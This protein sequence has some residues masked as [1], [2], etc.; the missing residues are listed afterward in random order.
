M[1]DQRAAGPQVRSGGKAMSDSGGAGM[2]RESSE[3]EQPMVHAEV[4]GRRSSGA[5][6][7]V[8]DRGRSKH[9][10]PRA[11][12]VQEEMVPSRPGMVPCY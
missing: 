4:E 1:E 5:E 11:P 2:P 12:H 7:R 8:T 9:T 6:V 10:K 3:A